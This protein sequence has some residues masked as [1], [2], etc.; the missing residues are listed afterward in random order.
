MKKILLSL[1]LLTIAG[2]THKL[3]SQCTVSNLAIEVT[4]FNTST[5]QIN[6]NIS[7]EQEVNSGNKFA[8]IHLWRSTA[9]HTPA[10]AW[11][12]SGGGV[13]YSGPSHYP[14]SAQLVNALATIAIEF[15]GTATPVIGTTYYPDPTVTPVSAGLSI[16]KTIL[17]GGVT[18]RETISGLSLTSSPCTGVVTFKGDIWAS[19]AANG[20]NVH[21]AV[22][23][24]SFD[25]NNPFITAAF[26]VCSPRSVTFGYKNNGTSSL[27]TSWKLYKDDGDGI[28]EPFS[29]QDGSAINTSGSIVLAA[30]ATHSEFQFAYAGS[31]TPGENAS[32]WLE[33][34]VPSSGYTTVAYISNSS[35]GCFSLPVDFKSFTATRNR[36]NVLLKWETAFEV[37]NTG[38]AIER[39]TN[40]SWEQVG[41]VAS[42]APGGN[43][44]DVLSY[45][46]ID[47]NNLKGISQYRL[48]QID[49]DS[50]SKYS[51]IRS[52]R[53][54]GQAGTVIV[55]PNP[56]IDGKVK[57][58]FED[59]LSVR[60]V[61][62]M[63]MNGRLVKQYKG[64]TNN[65]LQIENLQP[66]MYTLKVVVPATG[67]QT[68]T[69]IV[70]NKR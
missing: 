3:H 68:V 34:I 56:T 61:S 18:E 2:M 26:K 55:Y 33:V 22:Q 59:A 1:S 58:S 23:G 32:L 65:N 25:I 16:V 27:T 48:K 24:L 7:F 69:K 53:G 70:V 50:K 10:S 37:N 40:G 8:Y 20:K 36:S 6:F 43:S 41:F 62:V 14:E 12:T 29:G 45:Q 31:S 49:F 44:T 19:Q 60:D 47:N 9:Y 13:I 30:G 57:V 15:N 28:F 42:Q 38:F 63:D 64:I 67:E 21:C 39:N 4:S 35:A 11:P 5:C 51:E 46:F 54:D 17:P 66:G 52:V